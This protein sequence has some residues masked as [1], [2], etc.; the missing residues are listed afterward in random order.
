MTES[1]I[2]IARNMRYMKQLAKQIDEETKKDLEYEMG[3]L[4]R[5]VAEMKGAIETFGKRGYFRKMFAATKVVRRLASIERKKEVILKA[6]DR[7]IQRVQTDL[8]LGDRD[9]VQ[10]DTKEHTFALE[11]AVW[12]KVEEHTKTNGGDV[13]AEADLISAAERRLCAIPPQ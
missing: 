11:E 2:D 4:S 9:R 12:N 10:L 3:K 5:V 7:I 13:D 6:M 8:L 1:V